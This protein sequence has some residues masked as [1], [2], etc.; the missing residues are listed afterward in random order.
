MIIKELVVGPLMANCFICGCSKTKEAV[1]IDP[2]G[3][4]NTI[5]LSLADSKLKAKYIINTHGHFDHVSANGKMKDATGA[6]IL[7]HPLDAPMLEKLSSNAAFFGV[8]VEN[9]PPCD[10]TLEEGDTVSFGD[11]TLKVIH[12]PGH[13][14]G[15]ISLYTNGVVFVG[16]TLFAGSIGRTDFPGGDFN[17]LISSIKTKL[18]KMEDDIRVFSGHGPETSI[19]TEKRH[20]PFVGQF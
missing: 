1:V 7:I 17:T 15:G 12:T 9:S 6:D 14:P 18:F 20:N 3:D 13:T 4:A 10:Q 11:I 19:G 5:L 16:D 2:G 8:S